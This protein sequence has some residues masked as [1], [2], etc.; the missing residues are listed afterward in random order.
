MNMYYESCIITR[1]LDDV[2]LYMTLALSEFRFK[3]ETDLQ[4]NDHINIIKH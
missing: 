3:R 2:A 4:T 1:F